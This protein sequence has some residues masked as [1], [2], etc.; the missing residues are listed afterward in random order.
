MSTQQFSMARRWLIFST[1]F[2]TAITS[3]YNMYKA[4]PLFNA[5]ISEVGFT[6]DN[7][8]LMMSVFAIL[9]IIL[10]FPAGLIINK[11]GIKTSL[12]LCA[13]SMIIGST[14]GALAQDVTVLLVSRA[15]EG[16]SMALISVVAG[17]AVA[18]IIPAGQRGFA[19]G[20]CFGGFPFGIMIGMSLA[21][22]LYTA[23]G[24]TAAWWAGSLLSV[25]S[26]L[27]LVFIFKLPPPEENAETDAGSAESAAPAS[28]KP[29]YRSLILLGVAFIIWNLVWNGAF[30]SFYPTFL[31]DAHHLGATE[32]GAMTGLVN[33]LMLFM[34]PLAGFISDRLGSC[35]AI[36]VTAFFGTAVLFTVAFSDNLGFI[37]AF[38]IIES[39][40]AGSLG[41]NVYSLV[42]KLAR[43]PK[44][45][46][47]G[48]AIISFAQNTGIMIGSA[49]FGAITLSLGWSGASWFVLIPLLVIGGLIVLLLVK[50]Q[51]VKQS[52]QKPEPEQA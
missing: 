42:P 10:A 37:W 19:M 48:M 44:A 22:A 29:D 23:M 40:F 7:I 20:I 14:L 31:Q 16:I 34:G 8:G 17:V 4:P 43:Q 2:L 21:P 27:A 1:V 49:V 15:I 26:F 50:E 3:A 45:I 46:G 6:P 32:S 9:S 30:S 52:K 51:R 11:I 24:W 28:L 39:V 13:F 12:L 36:I 33:I 25:I 41:P 5:L 18:A 38:L 47:I 35:K